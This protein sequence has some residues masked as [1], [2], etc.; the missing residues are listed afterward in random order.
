MMASRQALLAIAFCTLSTYAVGAGRERRRHRR[1]IDIADEFIRHRRQRGRRCLGRHIG[2]HT[3]HGRD[4]DRQRRSVLLDGSGRQRGRRQGVGEVQGQS[5]RF[6]RPRQSDGERGRRVEQVDDPH[7]G[8]ERLPV[9]AH[10]IDG[11][12]ARRPSGQIDRGIVG[13][14]HEVGTAVIG[15]LLKTRRLQAPSF[16]R[17]SV[18]PPMVKAQLRRPHQFDSTLPTIR[19]S[20][21][22]R[23]C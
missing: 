22:R 6:E 16:S 23:N 12:R 7:Q 1:R 20:V 5:E 10:K 8:Q 14:H 9:V 4:V 15:K 11:A 3:G 18:L 13:E 2:L 21:F 17:Q 19:H